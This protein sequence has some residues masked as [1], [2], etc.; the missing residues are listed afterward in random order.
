MRLMNNIIEQVLILSLVLIPAT[1]YAE[2]NSF[3]KMGVVSPKVSQDA[4]DFLVR[5][6]KGKMVK[7]SDFK[8]KV[9]LLNFWATWCGACI[10]EMAS[11]QNLYTALQA[12][13]VEVLAVSI[14]R[15]NED[16]IQNYVKDNNYTF[17]VL[18]DQN[19]EVR[20][21]YH[22]MGLPTS[23]L[24]DGKGKIRGYASGAR[25]WDSADS[26]NLFLSLKNDGSLD[27]VDRFSMRST[28]PAGNEQ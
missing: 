25:T 12:E 17:P 1:G 8:G 21:K 18:L 15:W 3:G 22:V 13:G 7:L 10:E 27:A 14:D 26:Q 2:H 23:Y 19:Q 9:L 4:P 24:I 6:L 20:K 11:M 16:R 28:S 5:D